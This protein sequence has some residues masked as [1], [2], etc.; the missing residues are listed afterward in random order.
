MPATIAKAMKMLAMALQHRRDTLQRAIGLLESIQE[1]IS[2]SFT[3]AA[4]DKPKRKYIRKTPE[5]SIAATRKKASG[6]W[7]PARRRAQAARMRKI[8]LRRKRQQ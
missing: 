4:V 3:G 1:P 7:T 2:L 6:L 8:N 5:R